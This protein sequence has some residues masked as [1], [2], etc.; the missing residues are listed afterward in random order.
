MLTIMNTNDSPKSLLEAVKLFGDY[1][2]CHK[3]MIEARW[4]DGIVHCPTCG[5]DH[6]TYMAKAR[7]W[8]SY[9]KHPSPQFSLKVGTVFEDSP[10]ALETGALREAS[11]R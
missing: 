4:P 6:V 9:E 1:E 3:F 10:I 5:S 7:R 11:C 2:N 8:K